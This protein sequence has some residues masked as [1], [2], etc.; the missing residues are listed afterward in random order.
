M[1]IL[2]FSAESIQVGDLLYGPNDLT[3]V[4]LDTDVDLGATLPICWADDTAGEYDVVSYR[5]EPPHGL[6]MFV[7]PVTG[8]VARERRRGRIRVV[9]RS[10]GWEYRGSP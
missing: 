2:D 3:V 9:P 4:D 7:D 5:P 8:G 6:V 1:A 10:D